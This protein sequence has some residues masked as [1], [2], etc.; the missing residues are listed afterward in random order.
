[1]RNNFLTLVFLALAA[2]PQAFA[3]TLETRKGEIYEG[4]VMDEDSQ[5][6]YL[7]TPSGS[8]INL[9]KISIITVNGDP[10]HYSGQGAVPVKPPQSGS[11]PAYLGY[12][13]PQDREADDFPTAPGNGGEDSA[14]IHPSGVTE[15]QLKDYYA[16]HPD[17]FRMPV[18]MRFKIINAL[19]MNDSP[20]KIAQNPASSQAWKDAG[21]V[22]KGD[23]FNALFSS[24]EYDRIF[25]LKKGEAVLARDEYGVP[26]LFWA[27]DRKEAHVM[28][29]HEARPKVLNKILNQ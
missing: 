10:Y 12:R 19:D 1:M 16:A 23:S 25:N 4:K 7:E 3:D 14:V 6:V 17:E 11:R 20:E 18:E 8:V 2:S 21:W 24:A 13:N 5:F 26:C 15:K 9:P 27:T 28:P 29:Y 22:K